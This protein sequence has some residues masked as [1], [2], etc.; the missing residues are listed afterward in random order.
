MSFKV[1]H[2][3]TPHVTRNGSHPNP[4][5]F[6]P[7]K[8]KQQ[9][10]NNGVAWS[11]FKQRAPKRPGPLHELTHDL[12]GKGLGSEVFSVFCEFLGDFG[13]R[14]LGFWGF[15]FDCFFG[16]V[17][18][19]GVIKLP[20]CWTTM[21]RRKR[22]RMMMCILPPPS[23]TKILLKFTDLCCNIWE[24]KILLLGQRKTQR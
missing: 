14:V 21:R 24:H 6:M 18:W 22:R 7:P 20:I 19:M 15:F 2:P 17:R 8:K 5:F 13:F 3:F 1:H 10:C 4:N 9:P 16:C 11:S 23:G 12:K